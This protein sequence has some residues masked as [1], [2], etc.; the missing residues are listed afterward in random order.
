MD[1]LTLGITSN[2]LSSIA[3]TLAKLRLGG[4]EKVEKLPGWD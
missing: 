2:Y 3:A 4:A 1:P